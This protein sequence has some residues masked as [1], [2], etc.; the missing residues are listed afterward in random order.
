MIEDVAVVLWMGAIV[1]FI[2]I[3]V[4]NHLDKKNKGE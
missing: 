2:T 3:A 4:L 1:V